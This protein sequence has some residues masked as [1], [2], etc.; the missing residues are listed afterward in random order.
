M[1]NICRAKSDVHNRVMALESAKDLLRYPKILRTLVHKRLK[2]GPKFLL[3]LTISFSP[4]PS[5]ALYAALTWRPTAT[6]NE[7]ALG[8]FAAQI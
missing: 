5:H 4:S 3:T 8:S 6:L 7:T 1:S 2:T